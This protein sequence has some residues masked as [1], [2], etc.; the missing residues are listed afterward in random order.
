MRNPVLIKGEINMAI[1]INGIK[2]AGVAAPGKDG[3]NATING[4]PAL[5][6][7][8]T[9]GI[10]GTQSGDSFSLQSTAKRGIINKSR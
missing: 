7:V 5:T 4:V 8:A 3:V 9:G 6:L 10:K 1:S 2:I